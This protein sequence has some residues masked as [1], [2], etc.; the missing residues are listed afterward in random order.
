MQNFC[1]STDKI[2]GK[3]DC[4]NCSHHSEARRF[5]LYPKLPRILIVQLSRFD[6]A[7]NKVKTATP[8]P[9]KLNCF[10]TVCIESRK[11]ND[12][13]K[14]EYHLYGMIVHLGRTP[15][16]GHYMAYVRSMKAASEKHS[17]CESRS[18]CQINAKLMDSNE[19]NDTTTDNNWYICDDEQITIISQTDFDEK[20]KDE[21]TLRTPY[22]LFYARND[23][24][25][26][27]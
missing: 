11:N 18:C 7:M 2:S 4:P 26:A 23:I 21:A 13:M 24:I 25:E 20:I 17:Q 8:T 6:N 19:N 15:K 5:T 9:S 10:C 3:Y 16:S 1:L 14:H 12:K 27:Q 22:I